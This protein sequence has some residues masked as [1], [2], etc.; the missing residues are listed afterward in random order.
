MKHCHTCR[1]DKPESEFHGDRSR[2]G[3]LGCRCK[4]CEAKRVRKPRQQRP[5]TN[6]PK[7]PSAFRRDKALSKEKLYALAKE[8]DFV[9]AICEEKPVKVEDLKVDH[10][11]DTL[12]YR[13]LLCGSCNLLMAALD[14]PDW[15]VKAQKYLIRSLVGS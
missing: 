14:K 6:A 1:V 7:L 15:L 2:V 12:Q 5:R 13:G 3:G 10:C 9:C 8:Q 11:H 4:T